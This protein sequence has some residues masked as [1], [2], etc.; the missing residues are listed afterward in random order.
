MTLIGLATLLGGCGLVQSVTDATTSAT[1]AILYKQVKTLH[2]DLSA[3]TA[4]NTDARDMRALSVPT[5]VRIYQLRDSKLLDQASYDDIL[6]DSNKALGADL[7]AEHSQVVKPGEGVQL[8]VPLHKDAQFV[9]T[10]ALFREPDTST[11]SWR[12]MLKR[13]ELAPDQPRIIELG[14]NRLSLR[15]PARK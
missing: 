11:H 14:D 12:L 1:Q 10:V 15:A 7:L 3:R 9:A 13:D 6:S 5:L 2:L 4:M 8:N